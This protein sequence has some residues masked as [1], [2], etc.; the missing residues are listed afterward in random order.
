MT[1]HI[2][3]PQPVQAAAD[4]LGVPVHYKPV[5]M[6]GLLELTGRLLNTRVH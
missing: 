4:A 3:I 6:D 2:A 5:D 1:G